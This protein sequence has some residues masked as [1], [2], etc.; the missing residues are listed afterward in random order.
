[1]NTGGKKNVQ[2]K[3]RKD[4]FPA[5]QKNAKHHK[6][7][8]SIV[9]KASARGGFEDPTKLIRWVEVK[10]DSFVKQSE[11]SLVQARTTEPPGRGVQGWK[12]MTSR[13]EK[14]GV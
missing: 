1:M 2:K 8:E 10:E 14:R 7:R 3:G 4:N 5:L 12:E 13:S 9:Q 6:K 11:K